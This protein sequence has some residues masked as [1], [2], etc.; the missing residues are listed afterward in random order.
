M[1]APRTGTSH[2]VT[3]RSPRSPRW[4][5]GGRHRVWVD[6]ELHLIRRRIQTPIFG[7]LATRIFTP[8]SDR[9]PHTHSRWFA[10]FIVSGGYWEVVHDD[11]ADLSAGRERHH[12]RWSVMVLRRT[13][14]HRITSVEGKLRTF[15]VAGPWRGDF[16][17]WTDDGP[18]GRRE[19]G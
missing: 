12:G 3:S 6:G 13:Q 10:T 17:F 1:S 19:Y 9:A 14:A 11:P 15:V 8:D 18:V 4:G 2:P 7:L 5:F 16:E